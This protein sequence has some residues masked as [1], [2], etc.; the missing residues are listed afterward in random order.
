LSELMNICIVSTSTFAAPPTAYGG[1]VYFWNLARGICEAGHDVTLY[2]APGSLPPHPDCKCRLKYVPGGYGKID[3]K[4]YL[5]SEWYYSEIINNHDFVIDCQHMHMV[6]ETA[7][8]YHREHTKKI[9]VVPNGVSTE[10]PRCGPYSVVVGSQK[11]KE[12]MLY[13]RSQFYGTPYEEQYG[14]LIRSVAS[15]DFLGIV[16]WSVD[17]N[18]YTPGEARDDYFLWLSRPTPYKGLATALE[19]AARGRLKLKVAPGLGME[20]HHKEWEASLPLIEQAVKAGAQVEVVILPQNSQHHIMKRE[21]YRRARALIYP[22]QAHE[23]FGLV[24]TEA[25]SSGTPVIASTM[26]AMPEI[27]RHGETGFLCKNVDEFVEATK[28]VGALN[29]KLI[30]EDSEARWHYT[31]AAQEF[32]KLMNRGR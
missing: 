25:L 6:A 15:E 3:D 16:N 26:G 5:A 22:V 4:E 31:R 8:F 30:R 2:G 20:A 1:E 14:G 7:A 18:F 17:T 21:L 29:P 32:L 27:I 11:W 23:P 28:N 9:I 19:V 24:V 12:L 10:Y 13:G